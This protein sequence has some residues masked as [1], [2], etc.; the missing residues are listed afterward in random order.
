MATNRNRDKVVRIK[1]DCYHKLVN[2][3]LTDNKSCLSDVIESLIDECNNKQ[4]VI[5]ILAKNNT[6]NNDLM[7][8]YG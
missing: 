7:S 2:K 3:K 5:N 4:E 6:T 8:R 1:E